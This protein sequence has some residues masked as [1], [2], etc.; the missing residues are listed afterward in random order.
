MERTLDFSVH[1]SSGAERGS[2]MTALIGDAAY[3]PVFL[4]PEDKLLSEASHSA[5]MVFS[6]FF[7][8]QNR[9]PLIR[10]HLGSPFLFSLL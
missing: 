5:E 7:G 8:R 3:R 6:D 10:N 9:I 1:Q 2:A 4:P